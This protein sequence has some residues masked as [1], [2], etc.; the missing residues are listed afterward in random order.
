MYTTIIPKHNNQVATLLFGMALTPTPMD[1]VITHYGVL[2]GA[3]TNFG[4]ALL[5]VMTT[6]AT[7]VLALLLV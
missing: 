2:R 5:D 7:M 3:I 1:D 4:R 6:N